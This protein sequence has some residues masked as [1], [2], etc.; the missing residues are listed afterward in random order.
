MQIVGG[1]GTM[2]EK[3]HQALTFTLHSV[4]IWSYL[5]WRQDSKPDWPLDWPVKSILML[6]YSIVSCFYAW[7]LSSLTVQQ[8]DRRQQH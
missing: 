7:T 2:C 3:D 1:W 5:S 4:P 8:P 6:W